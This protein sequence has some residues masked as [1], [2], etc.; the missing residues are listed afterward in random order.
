MDLPSLNSISRLQAAL[1]EASICPQYMVDSIFSVTISVP[2]DVWVYL[3]EKLSSAQEIRTG[4]LTLRKML[5]LCLLVFRKKTHS[6]ILSNAGIYHLSTAGETQ[7]WRCCF[8]PTALQLLYLSTMC[9]DEN[10][11]D[12][13]KVWLFPPEIRTAAPN[14]HKIGPHRGKSRNYSPAS[15]APTAMCGSRGAGCIYMWVLEGPLKGKLQ[16]CSP[17][18]MG[19]LVMQLPLNHSR[20]PESDPNKLN[21][22]HT[23]F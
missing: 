5:P 3:K 21:G 4:T 14:P 16:R 11:R 8:L 15:C 7:T 19:F 10:A 23:A 22:S 20:S 6:F 1:T 17:A 9:A 2:K 18:G 13:I 12:W